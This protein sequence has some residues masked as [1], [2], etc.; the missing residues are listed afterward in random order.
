M[1]ANTVSMISDIVVGFSALVVAVLAFLG[2]RTWRNE[3]TGKAKYEIA[4]NIMKLGLKFVADFKNYRN[5]FSYSN[6]SKGR[7]K[8]DNESPEES[9]LLDQ[10]YI[11]AERV[12]PLY[13]N[14]NKLEELGWEV[15]AILREDD[16]KQVSDAIEVCNKCLAE[17]SSAIISYFQTRYEEIN[18]GTL[19]NDQ[20]WMRELHHEVY[21]PKKD[22]LLEKIVGAKDQLSSTLKKYVK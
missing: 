2:L 18:K 9:Q 19:I 6:E 13:E 7:Q 15:E 14:L 5:P 10:W 4:R 8:R 1:D 22:I 21:S 20:D 12:K 3:L 16:S 11:R 17:L